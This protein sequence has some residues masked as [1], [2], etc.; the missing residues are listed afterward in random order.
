L[1]KEIKMS[2]RVISIDGVNTTSLLGM[3]NSLGRVIGDEV[4]VR[5]VL[6]IKSSEIVLKSLDAVLDGV[7]QRQAKE[8]KKTD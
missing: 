1:G 5:E 2:K 6:E 8:P 3:V 7:K 4:Y